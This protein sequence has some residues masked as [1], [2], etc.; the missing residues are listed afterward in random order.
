MDSE[1]KRLYENELFHVRRSVKYHDHRKRFFENALNFAVFLALASGPMFMTLGIGIDSAA[2]TDGTTNGGSDFWKYVPGMITSVFAGMVLV[3]KAGAKANLHDRIR[4]RFIE[5]RQDMELAADTFTKQDVAKFTARR[6]G[7]EINEPPINRVVDAMSH[8][9][10]CQSMGEKRPTAYVKI[11]WR[12]RILGHFT[13][14]FDTSLA[15]YAEDDKGPGW[16]PRATD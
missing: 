1:V 5:L 14:S 2:E 6:L 8:N 13:R 10:V 16:L 15:L 7:I 12:H 3:S 11:R 9:A 4:E